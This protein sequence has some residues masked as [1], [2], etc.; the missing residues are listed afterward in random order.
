M[1]LFMNHLTGILINLVITLILNLRQISMSMPFTQV[2]VEYMNMYVLVHQ[3]DVQSVSYICRLRYTYWSIFLECSVHIDCNFYSLCYTY[4]D[5]FQCVARTFETVFLRSLGYAC[6]QRFGGCCI[7]CV[8]NC[9]ISMCSLLY[10]LH[11]IEACKVL[12]IHI[13]V[14]IFNVFCVQTTQV[15]SISVCITSKHIHSNVVSQHSQ[16]FIVLFQT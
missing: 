4:Q 7:Q 8:L 2:K 9:N 5:A 15:C 11:L 10:V 14:T 1:L 12:N 6:L 16:Y 13:S 3:Y